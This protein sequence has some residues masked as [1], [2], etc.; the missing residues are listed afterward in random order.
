MADRICA[1]R[2]AVAT[3]RCAC[4]GVDRYRALPTTTSP[5]IGEGKTKTGVGFF[6]QSLRV[7]VGKIVFFFLLWPMKKLGALFSNPLFFQSR[8]FLL[9]ENKSCEASLGRENF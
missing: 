5:C 6:G 7:V 1:S 8:P 2:S 3:G 9:G 4:T